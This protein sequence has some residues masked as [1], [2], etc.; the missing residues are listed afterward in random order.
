MIADTSLS[1]SPSRLAA[2]VK[3]SSSVTVCIE[4]F[5]MALP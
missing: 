1:V 3:L 5:D 4:D 2:I